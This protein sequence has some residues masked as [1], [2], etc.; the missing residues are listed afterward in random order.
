MGPTLAVGSSGMYR[1]PAH[2]SLLPLI[3]GHGAYASGWQLGTAYQSTGALAC[4]V[5]TNETDCVECPIWNSERTK[6]AAAL[7]DTALFVD[8]YR[9]PSLDAAPLLALDPTRAASSEA[10]ADVGL[11]PEI[12]S[13]LQPGRLC[14]TAK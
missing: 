14:N 5:Q 1:K 12:Y 7:N 3:G 10:L 6:N 8:N 2:M 4:Y 9:S 13:A 11:A